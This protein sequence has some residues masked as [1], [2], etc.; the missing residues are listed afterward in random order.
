MKKKNKDE[1]KCKE[2]EKKERK[3][4][5][6][7]EE[8]KKKRENNIKKKERMKQIIRKIKD[9]EENIRGLIKYCVEAKVYGILIW[10]MGL[11]LREGDREY[12]YEQLDKYFPGLKRRYI[13]TY[14]NQYEITS[15]NNTYLMRILHEECR[16]HGIICGTSE[17]FSYMKKFETKTKVQ[18]MSLFDIY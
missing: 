7:E 8:M 17:L 10:D 5:R 4:R 11:T 15:P 12:F 16:K 9:T 14:G 18:Q 3:K 1:E 13:A 2:N 6:G